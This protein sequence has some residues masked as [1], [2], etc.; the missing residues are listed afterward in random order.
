MKLGFKFLFLLII[1]TGCSEKA[2][3]VRRESGIFGMRFFLFVEQKNKEKFNGKGEGVLTENAF[4]CNIYDNFFDRLLI[5]I[6][7]KNEKGMDIYLH[8]EGIGYTIANKEMGNFFTK[9]FYSLF[10]REVNE[11]FLLEKK[12]SDDGREVVLNCEVL[13][14]RN[15]FPQRVAFK[16]NSSVESGIFIFDIIEISDKIIEISENFDF[17]NFYKSPNIFEFLRGVQ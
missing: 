8:E 6:F 15:S 11:G 14:T 7:F 9:N 2:F 5:T 10:K 3:L 17:S 1:F 16:V 4:K 12:F 13:K